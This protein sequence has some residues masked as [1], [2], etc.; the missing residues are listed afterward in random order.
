[1]VIRVGEKRAGDPPMLTANA[2]KFGLVAGNWK[3]YSLTDMI[4]H[5]WAW[6]QK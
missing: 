6:Y 3:Q 5:A 4:G 1:V 2:A